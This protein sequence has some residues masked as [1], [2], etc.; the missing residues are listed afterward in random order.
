MRVANRAGLSESSFGEIKRMVEGHKTLK[1]V[2]DWGM[3]QPPGALLPRIVSDVVV[4]DE[5]SHDVVVPWRE[6]LVLVYATT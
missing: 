1:D 3:G 2:L 4:Q 5:Y 6:G